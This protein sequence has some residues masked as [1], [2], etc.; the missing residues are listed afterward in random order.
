MKPILYFLFTCLSI[1]L[2]AQQ[3]LWAQN[4]IKPSVYING[5]SAITTDYRGNA[6]IA[7][8]YIDTINIGGNMLI[9]RFANNNFGTYPAYSCF[10]AEI[11]PNSQTAWTRTIQDT[12]VYTINDIKA[13]TGGNIYYASDIPTGSQVA[14]MHPNGTIQQ[15]LTVG[16]PNYDF[17]YASIKK[18]VLQDSFLYIAGINEDSLFIG[19]SRWG[20]AGSFIAKFNLNSNE[21]VWEKKLS[22]TNSVN[23]VSGLVADTSGNVFISGSIGQ[24]YNASS[25]YA[26][27]SLFD[28]I[29]V[30]SNGMS[31]GF[32]AKINEGGSYEWV[33]QYGT[34]GA[35]FNINICKDDQQNIYYAGNYQAGYSAI[36][37][38][39]NEAGQEIWNKPFPFLNSWVTMTG[40]G[41]ALYFLQN[42]ENGLFIPGGDTLYMGADTSIMNLHSN[43]I[44][45]LDTGGRFNWLT[46]YAKNNT[47]YASNSYMATAKNGMVYSTGSFTGIRNIG[48]SQLINPGYYSQDDEYVALLYNKKDSTTG[49]VTIS[50][51][52]Y[53]DN[54]NNCI[55]DSTD[56]ASP[57]Y[58]VIITPGNHVTATDILGFYSLN[59]PSGNYI[60]SVILPETDATQITA[61]CPS[62]GQHLTGSLA[63]GALDTL[64]DFAL[65]QSLC[66]YT[67]VGQINSHISC[68]M[69]FQVPVQ[70][71]NYTNHI[72]DSVIVL[73][74]ISD[75]ITSV[76][77]VP[78]YD[79]IDMSS[80]SLILS[81]ITLPADSCIQIVVSGVRVC[82]QADISRLQ[83]TDITYPL[84]VR[85][86]APNTCSTISSNFYND[87][88]SFIIPS[89]AIYG[90][91][92]MTD[93]GGIK[94]YPNPFQS[95]LLIQVVQPGDDGQISISDMTGREI[96]NTMLN[97]KSS[98][99]IDLGFL[100]SGMY[101]VI[102]KDSHIK[103]ARLIVKE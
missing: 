84:I 100:T 67:G 96:K 52:V 102:Y 93:H 80:G 89:N 49:S 29:I 56:V 1:S 12:N 48:S 71:C 57:Y 68:D 23:Y 28:T 30:L 15:I 75:S 31:D 34:N 19:G 27:T 82:T 7:G 99:T 2:P 60:V 78:A 33:K 41:D 95:T 24:T 86:Q 88:A 22:T 47:G 64:N 40:S 74:G 83:S 14:K 35:D 37:V 65:M 6:Y 16:V 81:H 36:L 69:P 32:V 43:S 97:G 45:C 3:Y 79:S 59:V 66:S 85:I 90:I 72:I 77:T 25:N 11:G 63:A 21:Y 73:L 20:N 5:I 42:D 94:I 26:D 46:T 87:S 38:K 4:Y 13:D 17:A 9:S 103:S 39:L 50:G 8:Q 18:I 53:F 55:F 101:S 61:T 62:N 44:M 51:R 10:I 70:I 91:P 54:N 98:L 76:S 92:D 58:G